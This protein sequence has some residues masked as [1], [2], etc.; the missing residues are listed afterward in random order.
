M[1]KVYSEPKPADLLRESQTGTSESHDIRPVVKQ[2]PDVELPASEAADSTATAAFGSDAGEHGDSVWPAPACSMLEKSAVVMQQSVQIFP[3][4]PEQFST[5]MNSECSFSPLVDATTEMANN[6]SSVPVKLEVNMQAACTESTASE[7]AHAKPFEHDS[8]APVIQDEGRRSASQQAESS[9]AL[10]HVHRTTAGTSGSNAEDRFNNRSSFRTKRIMNVW[11]TNQKLFMCCL[12]N[13]SF[14][15]LSQLEE[16]KSTHQTVKPF[17]C[18]ECGKCFTQKTRLKTHQSV[19]TGERP[20][21]C[22]ICG[23]MFSRQ[24]NCLRHERFHSG[25]KPYGC[26]QC[27]KS[28]TVLGN[29]KIHQEIHRQ[30]R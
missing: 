14:A 13:K 28:F 19:H 17:R 7:F 20:F 26:K 1:C 6:C 30:G 24:D 9:A 5:H 3:F 11:R 21:S 4:H 12:C 18:L 27:G 8:H 16:H 15:R 25:M 10:P 29:L 22:K 2:E 23:K